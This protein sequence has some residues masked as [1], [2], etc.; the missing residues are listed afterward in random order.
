MESEKTMTDIYDIKKQKW[1][2]VDRSRFGWLHL[3][4]IYYESIVRVPINGDLIF[5]DGVVSV[6]DN[7]EPPT[8]GRVQKQ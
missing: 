5:K 1:Y 8:P 4:S 6:L 3:S 2:S 7:P